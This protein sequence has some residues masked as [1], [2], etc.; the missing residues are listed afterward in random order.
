LVS[1]TTDRS[2]LVRRPRVLLLITLAEVGGAQAYVASL[3]PALAGRFEVVVA[4]HGPGP[5]R[6]AAAAA[7]VRFVGLEHVRRPINPW[8]DVAGFVELVRLLRRERPDIL[9]ASSS[10]AGALGRL[11]AFAARVPIRIFTVHGWAFAACSG[12][13]SSLYRWADRLVRPVTTVTIC[14]SE[15]ERA[16]GIRAGACSAER[17]VVIRNAVSLGG[18]PRARHG[19]TRP[20]LIAVGRLKA[21]KDFLTLV[22]A[23]AL[24]PPH[25]FEAL[26]VGD[27]PDRGTLEREVR[28]LGLENRVRLVGERHDVPDLLAAA[29]VFV[30]SSVSEGL[31]VSVLEAMAAE[32]PVVASRVGGLPELVLDGLTGLLVEPRNAAKLADALGLLVADPRLRRRLGAAGLKYAESHFDPQSFARAH[33]DVYADELARRSLPVPRAADRPPALALE[34]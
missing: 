23:F 11:A 25:S 27:G 31:P 28:R 14:V 10:K 16:A 15:N 29:D 18:R 8:R 17:T 9:H 7:G 30:L 3:L 6:A 34:R 19:T 26:I 2:E 5:L 22:R 20:L 1:S 24:L 32:L 13:A 21:P 12:P 33:V 4:A